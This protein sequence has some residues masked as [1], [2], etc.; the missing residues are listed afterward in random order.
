MSANVGA[1]WAKKKDNFILGSKCE[2]I[3]KNASLTFSFKKEAI[4]E[5]FQLLDDVCI[6]C[7][8]LQNGKWTT[9]HKIRV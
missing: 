4:L 1:F 7:S 3:F 2:L 5:N 9:R 8:Y 6:F